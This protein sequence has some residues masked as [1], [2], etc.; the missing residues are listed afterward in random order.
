MPFGIH[1][2]RTLHLPL[3]EFNA[4]VSEQLSRLLLIDVTG[5]VA[6]LLLKLFLR[7]PKYRIPPPRAG[8]ALRC[9]TP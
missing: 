9:A 8:K 4:H 1:F 5:P 6:G 3:G 7:H 2:R